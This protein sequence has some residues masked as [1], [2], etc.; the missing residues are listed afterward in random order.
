MDNIGDNIAYNLSRIRKSKGLSLDKVSE[1]TGVSK[2][3]LSQIEKGASSP[4]VA[5]LWKI[6]TGLQLNFTALLEERSPQVA[7]V[8]R[9]QVPALDGEDGFRSHPLFAY[10]PM[11]RIE[12]YWVEMEP[13]SIH[14]SEAHREG[15]EEYVMV[16]YGLL[17]LE[18]SGT[19][20]TIGP[21]QSLRFAAST[22]HRYINAAEQGTGYHTLVVYSG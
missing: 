6:A 18:I 4:T 9:S 14:V 11:T 17:Q 22:T 13:G 5:V 21:G 15:V 16:E 20:H 8:D 1:L 7:I 19:C 12:I 10:D 2:G 3:M